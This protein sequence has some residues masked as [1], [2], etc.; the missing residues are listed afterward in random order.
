MKHTT[1]TNMCA[2]AVALVTTATTFAG[3]STVASVQT[4]TAKAGLTGSLET[5]YVSNYTYHG[6]LIDSNP[7]FVPKLNL[8]AP[9]F[10]GGSLKFSAEQVVGTT[11]STWFRSKYNVGLAL[12][13]GR[14]TVTPGF[15]VLAYPGRD[16]NNSRSVTARLALDDKGL[17]PLTLNPYVYAS[18][19]VDPRGGYYYEVGVAPG[20]SYGK[21]DVT[22]PVR[23]GA[24]SENYYKSSGHNATYAFAG[25]G[26]AGTYHV[27]DRFALK[28][29]VT[30]FTTDTRL[31]NA[32][33]SYVQSTAGVAV[34]F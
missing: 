18:H 7:V 22:V 16:G 28:A 34:S 27:T 10:E 33:N 30:Y 11:G 17:L 19:A 4:P 26:L 13:A 14:V 29:G 23:V 5:S 6:Q 2:V 21:L 9:L 8:Q 15:E 3:S 31:G 20:K 12:N 1:K 32:S 24:S 25:A